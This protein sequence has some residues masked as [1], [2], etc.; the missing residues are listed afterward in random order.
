MLYTLQIS[1]GCFVLH[2]C[3]S[4]MCGQALYVPILQFGCSPNW[5]TCWSAASEGHTREADPEGAVQLGDWNSQGKAWREFWRNAK[6]QAA[7]V[8]S[9]SGRLLQL[10]TFGQGAHLA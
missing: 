7:P 3:T 2:T 9:M 5:S 4:Q 10:I 6:V 1:A 8:P